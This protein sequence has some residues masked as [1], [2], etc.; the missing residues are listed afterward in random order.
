MY[1]KKIIVSGFT[2]CLLAVG[3][4]AFAD[5]NNNVEVSSNVDGNIPTIDLQNG[6]DNLPEEVVVSEVMTFDELAAEMAKNK[7]ITEVEAQQI[8]LKNSTDNSKSLNR[9]N[10][11]E[12]VVS[13]KAAKFRTIKQYLPEFRGYTPSLEFYCETNE[14][15]SFRGIVKILNTDL[16]PLSYVRE[17][18]YVAKTF[19]GT[20]Y[21]NL[22]N[23][24]KIHYIVKGSFYNK[25][26]VSS[27]TGNVGLSLGGATTLGIS[28]TVSDLNLFSTVHW[29]GD[30]RF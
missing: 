28:A 17:D 14:S 15:G 30:V 6:L 7:G 19:V 24:N 29:P 23:A 8:I 13:A 1:L 26:G 22:E 12:G 3:S 10:N 4:P 11:S 16:N 2:V 20:V 21:V 18:V 25:G 27:V 9:T 5:E